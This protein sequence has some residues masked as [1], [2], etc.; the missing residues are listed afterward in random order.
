MKKIIFSIVIL[1]TVIFSACDSS[2]NKKFYKK[3]TVTTDTTIMMP[4]SIEVKTAPRWSCSGKKLPQPKLLAV[5]NGP[6]VP[7]KVSVAKD[8]VVTFGN[9]DI[10]PAVSGNSYS[11]NEGSGFLPDLLRWLLGIILVALTLW[12]LWW[13]INNLPRRSIGGNG[14]SAGTNAATGAS[15]RNAENITNLTALATAIGNAG[16]GTVEHTTEDGFLFMK[17]GPDAPMVNVVNSGAG[18]S[19]DGITVHVGDEHRTDIRP[20]FPVQKQ[21]EKPS[22][23]KEDHQ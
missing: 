20:V 23:K 17:I 6:M 10:V 22:D 12:G 16:G 9:E 15:N 11:S 4:G 1:F 18:A 2:D 8:T 19:S 7:M 13:L 14:S 5:E 21:E 3:V